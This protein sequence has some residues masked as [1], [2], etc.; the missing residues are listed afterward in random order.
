MSLIDYTYF[1][2]G[3]VVIYN[4]AGTGDINRSIQEEVDKYVAIFEK[5]CL[6]RLLGND[7]YD[8]FIAGLA[9]SSVETRWSALK[10]LLIDY[11]NKLSPIASYV[12]YWW[13]VDHQTVQV[14]GAQTKFNASDSENAINTQQ[15]VDVYNDM[16]DEFQDV[17]D[18][19]EENS[20]IYPEWENDAFDFA[21]INV[22][23][24]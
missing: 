14:A 5:K 11:Q 23:D 7:L 9:E 13:L 12:W 19:I 2:T 10:G 8:A 20:D 21:K 18:Y 24:I 4:L 6:K 1:Q 3:R 15:I 22:F 16:V 17:Y